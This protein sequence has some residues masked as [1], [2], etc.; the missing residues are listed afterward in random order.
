MSHTIRSVIIPAAGEGTRLLPLTL[1]LPKEMLPLYDRPVLQFAI[2]EAV[3]SGAQRIIIVTHP[4]KRAIRDFLSPSA[5]YEDRLRASGKAHL[6]DRIAQL[7]IP[8]DVELVVVNQPQPSGL[9]SAV[10]LCRDQVLPGAVGII[11]PDDLVLGGVC[12]ADMANDYQ[13]GHMVAAQRVSPSQTASYGI[14]RPVGKMQGR[15]QPAD[16]MVEKPSPRHAPSQLAAVGRYILDPTIF[17]TLA[18]T[19]ADVGGEV[20]LTDAIAKD[21]QRIALTAWLIKG[22][23]HDCGTLDGLLDAALA[24]RVVRQGALQDALPIGLEA[25]I[26]GSAPAHSRMN[27]A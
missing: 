21:A 7:A 15:C 19:V 20:Q 3:A 1:S 12:L 23:R 14:F 17:A 16:G 25:T 8:K 13:G 9:G 4:S 10:A 5:V 27:G 2:E 24:V 11:L 26:K 6:A 18:E 22:V